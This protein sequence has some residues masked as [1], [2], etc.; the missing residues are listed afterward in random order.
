MF[1]FISV[2]TGYGIENAFGCHNGWECR[3]LSKLPFEGI[4]KDALILPSLLD[5]YSNFD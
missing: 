1:Y 4:L 5:N 2:I 3:K